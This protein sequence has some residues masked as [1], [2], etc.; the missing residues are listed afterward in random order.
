METY[1]VLYSVDSWW[2]F[3]NQVQ[4]RWKTQSHHI[5]LRRA[6]LSSGKRSTILSHW[7]LGK[8]IPNEEWRIWD[9]LLI[10][11]YIWL[12]YLCLDETLHLF[13]TTPGYLLP[14]RLMR[15]LWLWFCACQITMIDVIYI[16]ACKNAWMENRDG[17]YLPICVALFVFESFLGFGSFVCELSFLAD[18]VNLLFRYLKE[19]S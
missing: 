2:I 6:S 8:Q 10:I 17:C 16:L 4:K 7:D 13:C 14:F 19:S 12:I 3:D 15:T 9:G 18:F 5:H 1:S 11:I